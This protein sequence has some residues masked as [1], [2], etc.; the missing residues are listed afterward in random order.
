MAPPVRLAPAVQTAAL[1]VLTMALGFPV[2]ASP[3]P[4]SRGH[5]D[6]LRRPLHLPRIEAG[7]RCPVSSV[8][9]TVPFKSF[10]I[11][12]GLGRGPVYPVGYPD[13]VLFVER[14]EDGGWP[15][16]KVLWFV[17]ERY[18]GPVLLRG[19]RVDARDTL[20]FGQGPRP[21]SELRIARGESVSWT[22]QQ[23]GSRGKPSSVRVRGPGCYAVQIDGT[24]FSRVVV[25]SVGQLDS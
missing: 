8:D 20:R 3:L 17:H 7:E 18:R 16:T 13:G 22:G 9:P 21:A 6:P 23:P 25:F 11:G 12:P 15:G 24:S 14:N 19:R 1:A 10:G 5:E 2:S 4:P